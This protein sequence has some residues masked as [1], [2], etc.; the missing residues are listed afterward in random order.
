V[1]L[2]VPTMR[3]GLSGNRGRTKVPSADVEIS[4]IKI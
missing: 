4:M 2:K 3:L 1:E